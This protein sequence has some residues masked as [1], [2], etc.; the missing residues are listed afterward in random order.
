MQ[1]QKQ[2]LKAEAVKTAKNGGDDA[3]RSELENFPSPL[4]FYCE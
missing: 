1:T 2:M 3:V 4:I